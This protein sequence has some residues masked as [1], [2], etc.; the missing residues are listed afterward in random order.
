MKNRSPFLTGDSV[1]LYALNK[2]DLDIVHRWRH[3]EDI[4]IPYGYPTQPLSFGTIDKNFVQ[5]NDGKVEFLVYDPHTEEKIGLM[6]LVFEDHAA[7]T[8][9]N[10][11]FRCLIDP[12]HQSNGHGR[13]STQLTLEYGFNTLNL[14]KIWA[15]IIDSNKASQSNVESRGFKREGVL[16]D[17]LYVDGEYHDVYRYGILRSEWEET[18]E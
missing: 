8:S 17:E 3:A 9:R 14:N 13:E 12:N 18:I 6:M 2:E 1:H 5:D 11:E 15:R 16:R 7:E 4:R 10:A